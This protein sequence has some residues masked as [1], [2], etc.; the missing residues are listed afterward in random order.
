LQTPTHTIYNCKGL[1]NQK[2]S[3]KTN[4]I[5]A[6]IKQR[7]VDPDKIKQAIRDLRLRPSTKQCFHHK[8][9]KRKFNKENLNS[10][11]DIFLIH[12]RLGHI[13]LQKIKQTAARSRG[14]NLPKSLPARIDCAACDITQTKRIATHRHL[15]PEQKQSNPDRVHCDF[16]FKLSPSTRGYQGFALYVHERTRFIKVVIIK[17]KSESIRATKDYV[18]Q[19]LNDRFINI[20]ELRTDGGGEYIDSTLQTWLTS[21]GIT[22]TPSTPYTPEENS[23]SERTIQKLMNAT[24]A[25]IK[26]S[27]LSNSQWCYVLETAAYLAN[28]TVHQALGNNMSPFEARYKIKP[29]LKNLTT[30]GCISVAPIPKQRKDKGGLE[31]RATFVRMLAYDVRYNTFIVRTREGKIYCRKVAKWYENLFRFP[32]VKYLDP[33][34][35]TVDEPTIEYTMKIPSAINEIQVTEL[36]EGIPPNYDYNTNDDDKEN[37]EKSKIKQ[38]K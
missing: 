35:I 26:A 37:N 31:D 10:K 14:L 23:I 34:K 2:C 9:P 16:K 20:T 38:T 36:R 12:R 32:R 24:R 29:N 30:W 1:Q 13:S 18:K 6:D 28:R 27:G 25:M 4:K 7:Q 22:W 5:E 3:P 15:R 8:E 19:L 21:Q 11:R 33:V 17:T